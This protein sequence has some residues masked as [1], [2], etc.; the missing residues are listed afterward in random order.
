M[1]RKYEAKD[2]VY[3]MEIWLDTNKKAHSFIPSTYWLSSY[4]MVQEQIAQAK[5]YVYED[6]ETHQII[7]FIGLVEE[8]IAG[9][10]VK[11]GFQAKGVGKQLLDYVKQEYTKLFLQVYQKNKRAIAFYEREQFH[12][13]SES[14]DE[15]T[16]EKEWLMYWEKN[17][18]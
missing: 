12:I 11:E 4:D 8:H 9:L 6:E 18:L 10:F 1:V 17:N 15:N 5:L 3:V 7:G 13:Q 2:L 16:Q 14:V